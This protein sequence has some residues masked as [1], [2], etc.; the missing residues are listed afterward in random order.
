M[1]MR[2]EPSRY[3][4]REQE[5]ALGAVG[6]VDRRGRP[7]GDG[8]PARALPLDAYRRGG[9]VVVHLDIPGVDPAG[10]ELTAEKNVLTV[11]AERSFGMQEGDEVVASERPHGRF[12]RDIYLGDGFDLDGIEAGYE[13]GVLTITVP[14]ARE[15]APRKVAIKSGS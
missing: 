8:V 14:V 13:Q 1:A 12:S 10:I 6:P 3:P 15:A 7:T 4:D 2:F 5:G 9:G 11:R